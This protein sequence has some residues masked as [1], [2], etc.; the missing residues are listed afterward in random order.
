MSSFSASRKRFLGRLAAAVGLLGAAPRTLAQGAVAQTAASGALAAGE[1]SRTA[2]GAAL[3]RAAHQVYD[4]PL[5]FDDPLALSVVGASAEAELRADAWRGR[6]SSALRALVVLRSRHA[7]DALAAAHAR[8]IRQA[9]VLGAGL[10]TFGCRNPYA[11][12]LKVY[13]VDHPATQAWKRARLAESGIAVPPALTFA[14]VDFERQTLGAALAQAG[15]RADQ[16]TFVT[17]LGVVVYLTRD[18]AFE[19]LKFVASLPAK[20]EIVFDYGVTEASLSPAEAAARRAAAARVAAIGEPWITWFD[21][22]LLA[23]QL[24]SLGFSGVDDLDP[25]AANARY[26]AGRND[27]LAVSRGSH[28]MRARV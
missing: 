15:F 1:P 7:E 14:P 18:A 26:F 22:P 16:P 17:L 5:V 25:D 21:P 23:Q 12:S 20:S 11:P 27:A 3:L 19:T 2:R 28:I 8:G 10:D 24:R 13:E 6:G 9:L 4:R